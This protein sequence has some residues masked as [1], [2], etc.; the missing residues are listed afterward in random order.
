[1]PLGLRSFTAISVA[2]HAGVF[3]FVAVSSTFKMQSTRQSPTTLTLRTNSKP[4]PASAKPS[5]KKA[6]TPK[7]GKPKS[8][9]KPIAKVIP[10]M[11]PDAPTESPPPTETPVLDDVTNSATTAPSDSVGDGPPSAEG[12]AGVSLEREAQLVGESLTKPEYTPEALKARLQGLFPVDIHLSSKGEVLE[13]E[14]VQSPGFG[15][16]ARIIAALQAA[17]YFSKRDASGNEMETWITIQFKL[18]IP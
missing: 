13:I 2:I 15:M 18:E 1:V 12:S 4:V 5:Q 16:D 10:V 3:G 7:G 17:K 11:R 8:V 6:S 9:S 14:L